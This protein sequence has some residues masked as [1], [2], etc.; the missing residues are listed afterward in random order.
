MPNC[1][2]YAT[3]EDHPAL[4]DWLFAEQ[5]CDVYEAYSSYEKPL[6]RFETTAEVLAEF[7]RTYPTGQ[8]WV[9]VGLQLYV[10]GSGPPFNAKRIALDPKACGGATFRFYAEGW[11]LVQLYLQ[12]PREDRLENSHTNHN[13][14]RRAE[15]WA[16]VREGPA[17]ADWDFARITSFSSR[18]NRQIKKQAVGK[19]NSRV[20]H[21]CALKLW[22]AGVT[23][24]P[25][26]QGGHME[27]VRL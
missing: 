4:L 14:Q 19:L 15:N 1:D 9:S 26:R 23:L 7:E 17:P 3:P 6:R 10:R 27:M 8:K 20:V 22:D 24:V 18:L 13:S 12:A 5:T 16:L 25:W 11:G 21:R 2:Y